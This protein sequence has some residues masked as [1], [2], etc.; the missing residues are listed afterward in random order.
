MGILS[1]IMHMILIK[2]YIKYLNAPQNDVHST[3][4]IF[5]L[6]QCKMSL[7]C[8]FFAFNLSLLKLRKNTAFFQYNI[9][10]QQQKY[11]Y[12]MNTDWKYEN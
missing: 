10:Q 4:S 3:L 9:Q 6:M 1:R 5:A 11:C 8:L 2:N 12:T 7:I